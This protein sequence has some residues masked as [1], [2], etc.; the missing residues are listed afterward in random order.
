M[1]VPEDILETASSTERFATALPSDR[2]FSTL[3]A[4]SAGICLDGGRMERR[5]PIIVVVRLLSGAGS[6]VTAIEGEKTYTDNISLHGARVFSRF[7]WKPGEIV[8]IAPLNSQWVSGRVV[9]S[10]RLDNGLHVIGLNL[11]DGAIN[12]SILQRLGGFL[13]RNM[14]A[15][16]FIRQIQL[17]F[18]RPSAQLFSTLLSI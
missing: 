12:W 6:D 4:G 9:Y 17:L 16:E 5:F 3:G 14:R 2:T 13:P 7:A 8:R 1:K 10:Q 15:S 18:F 11:Q